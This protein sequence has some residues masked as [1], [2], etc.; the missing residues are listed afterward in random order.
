[1]YSVL[2]GSMSWNRSLEDSDHVFIKQ[3]SILKNKETDKQ[4]SF[5]RMKHV[6]VERQYSTRLLDGI[7]DK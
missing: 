2:D 5:K 4:H 6:F 7:I 3:K 1:M